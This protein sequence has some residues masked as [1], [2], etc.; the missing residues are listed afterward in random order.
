[1]PDCRLHMNMGTEMP[2]ASF[3]SLIAHLFLQVI[4]VLPRNWV[5][6]PSV[7]LMFTGGMLAVMIFLICILNYVRD[8]FKQVWIQDCSTEIGLQNSVGKKHCQLNVVDR[9]LKGDASPLW[10]SKEL[11]RE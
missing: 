9:Q 5:R 3:Q 8:R 6:I 1:M 2:E 10:W 11:K 4:I 7:E